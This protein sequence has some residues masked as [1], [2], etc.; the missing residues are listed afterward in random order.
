MK[1]VLYSE[2][3]FPVSGGVQTNIFELACGLS[4]WRQDQSNSDRVEVTVITRTA[5]R[6]ADDDSWPFRLVRRPGF[7]Q[8]VQLLCKADVIHIAGP[9]LVPVLVGL[10]LRKPVLIEHHGY[11]SMCPNGVLLLGTDRTVCPG[12]FMAANYERCVRCN[13]GDMGWLGSLRALVLLFP[14]RWLCKHASLNIAITDHVA[15]RIALPRTQTILYGIRDPGSL[16]LPQN[17]NAVEIG[18]VGRLVPEKGLL[19]LLKAARRLQNDGFAYRL[20]FVGGGP[21]EKQL[22]DESRELGIAPHVTFA[23][24]LG[25]AD[26]ERAVRPLQ[27]VVM[28]SMWEETAGLAAIEQ[29][30]RGGVVVAS[31]IGGLSEV[32][33]DAG[34]K[35]VPGDSDALYARLREVLESPSLAVS[36]GDSARAR[37]ARLFG[38]DKMI[39]AHVS[40][41]LEAMRR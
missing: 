22:E 32:V 28:P 41:Y 11:Q 4:E 23:G 39:R 6:T 33:G 37:A 12:H 35:F 9:A 20:T 40:A 17:G 25:G 5:E 26:L 14:R 10:L 19:V 7:G 18:Y 36:I 2:Y 13:S 8:L 34:L 1:V 27:I 30:M 16:R 24:E 15:R 21:L 31:D 29:M 3:F 38:R